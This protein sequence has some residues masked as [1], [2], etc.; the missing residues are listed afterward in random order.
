MCY[1]CFIIWSDASVASL[2]LLST[3]IHISHIAE[4]LNSWMATADNDD[5]D[6][7]D[8][9]GVAHFTHSRAQVSEFA[10]DSNILRGCSCFAVKL[11]WEVK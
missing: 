11:Y 8:I 9:E 5:D 3:I 10:S 6:K 7:D 4:D 2:L 1:R